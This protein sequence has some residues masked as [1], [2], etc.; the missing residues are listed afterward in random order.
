MALAASPA[1]ST[2]HPAPGTPHPAPRTPHP[3]P[4]TRHPAPGTWHLSKIAHKPHNRPLSFG[5]FCGLWA[6]L[7]E[8]HVDAGWQQEDAGREGLEAVR[9]WRQ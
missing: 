9:G 8:I 4:G 5:R 7:T 1:P 6:N 3:A 2:Q